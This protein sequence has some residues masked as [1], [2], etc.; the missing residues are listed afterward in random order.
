MLER[1]NHTCQVRIPGV[2]IGIGNTVD[3][4]HSIAEGGAF[5]DQ[6]NCRASCKPCN[7]H[8]GRKLGGARTAVLMG[9][10]SRVW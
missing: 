8:R 3:H 10:A 6:N 2:C 1:D 4:I 7:E 5:L 9:K